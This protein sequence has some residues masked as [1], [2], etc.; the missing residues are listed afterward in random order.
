[1]EN[2]VAVMLLCLRRAKIHL[3]FLFFF[4]GSAIGKP[5]I[6]AVNISA[7]ISAGISSSV[8]AAAPGEQY[9]HHKTHNSNVKMA[10]QISKI[11]KQQ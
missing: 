2:F 7:V 6:S 11:C 5:R 8:K 9:H 10:F 1:M 3:F 4:S